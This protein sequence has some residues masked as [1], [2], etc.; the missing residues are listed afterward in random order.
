MVAA[1]RLEALFVAA[2]IF[3]GS[4]THASAPDAIPPLLQ[5][6]AKTP[7][8]GLRHAWEQHWRDT[9]TLHPDV[10][11]YF[12]DITDIRNY[13]AHHFFRFHAFEQSD[14]ESLERQGQELTTSHQDL[15]VALMVLTALDHMR[16]DKTD[17]SQFRE[18]T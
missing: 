8:G 4:D 11:A 9:Q 12:R 13:L 10:L 7:L 15:E 2:N 5:K 18:G 14:T 3:L 16:R 17:W 6:L 1:Q